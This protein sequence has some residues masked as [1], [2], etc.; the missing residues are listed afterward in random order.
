V[1]AAKLKLA[2]K[3]TPA[4]GSV[5]FD[6]AVQHD[7]RKHSGTLRRGDIHIGGAVAHLMGGY[8]EQG[9][10]VVLNMKLAGP[11]MPVSELETM[12]PALGVALPAGSRLDG[13]TASV[14]LAMEGPA[15]KL[16]TSGSLALNNTRLM[17]FDLPKK[18]STIEKLAGIEGGGPTRRFRP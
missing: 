12:L 17:G 16:V 5:G 15:D 2:K 13:G 8:A 3:G 11:A 18:M 4:A 1:E 10:S 9:D 14:T 6:F 7:L